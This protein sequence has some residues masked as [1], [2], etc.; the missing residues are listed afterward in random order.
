[1]STVLVL[2]IVFLGGSVRSVSATTTDNAKTLSN[3]KPS[4]IVSATALGNSATVNIANGVNIDHVVILDSGTAKIGDMTGSGSNWNY[5][6]NNLNAG[7]FTYFVMA[8]S[9]P[10][11]KNLGYTDAEVT[12]K[13]VSVTVLTGTDNNVP[14][15]YGGNGQIVTPMPEK[16]KITAIEYGWSGNGRQLNYIK[17]EPP[18]VTSKVLAVFE[19]HGFEDAY[20]KDGQVL[21]DIANGLIQSFSNYPEKLGN[22]ALYIVPAANPDGLIDGWSNNDKGRNQYSLGVDINRD[23]DYCWIARYNSRNK[24]LSPF[25]A[26][27]SRALRDLVINIQPDDV[28]DIHGWLGTTY[29]TASL[30]QYFENTIGI[31]RSSGLNGSSGYFSAWSMNYAKRTALIELPYPGVNQQSVINAFINLCAVR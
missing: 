20:S 5:T 27:E 31:G 26:P 8:Y 2:L 13:L 12:T 15:N 4:F 11:P 21:V 30:T 24:T 9:T 19:V 25:S 18:V 7:A 1:M 14:I 22:T 23:F 3:G 17:I 29:G 10:T 6:I 28:I 16:A